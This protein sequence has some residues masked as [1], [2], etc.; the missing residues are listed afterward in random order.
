MNFSAKQRYPHKYKQRLW[1]DGRWIYVYAEEG[2]KFSDIKKTSIPHVVV[3]TEGRPT[4][5]L[6]DRNTNH[7]V[8]G[9]KNLVGRLYFVNTNPQKKYCGVARDPDGVLDPAYAYPESQIKERLSKK[10]TKYLKMQRAYRSLAMESNRMMAS[11]DPGE[12]DVGLIIYLNNN[13]R[14]RI[15]AHDTAA[16]VSPIARAAILKRAREENWS[17]KVLAVR[18]DAERQPTF[19]LLSLQKHH[20]TVFPDKNLV[21]FTF[22][23]KGGKVNSFTESVSPRA[24]FLLAARKMDSRRGMA[25]KL[26]QHASYKKILGRYK[27]YGVT[28]HAVR[29][30]YADALVKDLIE[31][32]ADKIKYIPGTGAQIWKRFQKEVQESVSDNLQHTSDVTL[33]SYIAPTTLAA[34]QEFKQA[35]TKRRLMESAGEGK[36]EDVENLAEVCLWFELGAGNTVA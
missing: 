35:L 36:E 11:F 26:F 7:I 30:A 9:P 3:L 21:T 18:M 25:D 33:K 22:M 6:V 29:G 12:Q 24:H 2:K 14:M 27:K 17:D 8:S 13:T 15:G 16:S 28:P 32:Y 20:L 31:R 5:L 10:A 34:L 4:T 19:G 23:G 1:K